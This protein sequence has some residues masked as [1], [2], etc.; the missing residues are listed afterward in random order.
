MLTTVNLFYGNVFYIV[1]RAGLAWL[2]FVQPLSFLRIQD[3]GL[4]HLEFRQM[5]YFLSR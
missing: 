1:R 2:L 5:F 3:G 4:G